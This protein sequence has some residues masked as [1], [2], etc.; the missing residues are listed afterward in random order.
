MPAVNT[1]ALYASV[2]ILI[3][4]LLQITAFVCLLTLHEQRFEV[5]FIFIL[6]RKKKTFSKFSNEIHF[7]FQK[8][9][10]DVLCCMKTKTDN[11]MIGQKFNVVHMI[12]E[13]YYTPFLMKTPV[14]IIV[15]IIF[16]VSLIMHIVIVPQIGVGLEQKLSMPEDSYVLKYFEVLFYTTCIYNLQIFTKRYFEQ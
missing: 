7:I 2:S 9:Y 4:F 5:R 15:L 14:R 6:K 11:F 10:F 12:F 1:F 13:R 8:R 3:N 16:F